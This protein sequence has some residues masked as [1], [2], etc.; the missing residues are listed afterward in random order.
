MRYYSVL[1]VFF[2]FVCLSFS[3]YSSFASDSCTKSVNVSNV[4]PRRD[5][6]G[7]WMDVH[8][9]NLF[10]DPKGSNRY[11]WIGMGYQNCTEE[12]GWIPPFDCPGIYR[13]FGSCGFRED[14]AIRLYASED[15]VRWTLLSEDVFPAERRPKG[16]YFR[17]KLIYHTIKQT[18]VLWINY[19]APASTPLA[20][21][22]NATFLVATA[23]SPQGPFDVVTPRAAV[24]HSGGG[25]FTL[26][27]DP[28]DSN[29]TA[30]I[31]YDAWSNSHRVV[32]ETLNS[33][34]TDS[35]GA[36]ASAGPLSPSSHEAPIL[37][38]RLGYYYLLFGH[39]CCFCSEGAGSQVMVATHPLGPWND[40]GVDINPKRGLLNG[41]AVRAQENFVFTISAS[42]NDNS[43]TATYVYT[44]DR[45]RSAPDLLKSHDF[46]YWEPLRFDDSVDP[47]TIST[48]T[49]LDSF[50]VCLS[51]V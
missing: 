29:A 12:K 2:T 1:S 24:A 40:T 18:Y 3:T 37:F 36:S 13:K 26:M 31:A 50:E 41:R 27:I 38:E 20:A 45:W 43:T 11:F 46:Q 49:W 14:H 9:G 44:G 21:Y 7:R 6:R 17:P 25:D 16:I 23:S 15:L 32:V 8:D 42:S 34:Y 33:D 35:L 4:I 30:Y 22:P 19:L 28:N 47:P 5:T 10:A 39:T 51:F 48:L